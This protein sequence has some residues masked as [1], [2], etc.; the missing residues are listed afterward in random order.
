MES[1]I[2]RV[3]KAIKEAQAIKEC[4][5]NAYYRPVDWKVSDKV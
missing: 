3:H 5:I 4:V 2:E 1:T